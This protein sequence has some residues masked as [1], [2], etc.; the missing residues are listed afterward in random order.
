MDLK[1]VQDDREMY[2]PTVRRMHWS[3]SFFIVKKGA[4]SARR[5]SW[6][7]N[8]SRAPREQLRKVL[9]LIM[10]TPDLCFPSFNSLPPLEKTRSLGSSVAGMAR[11]S[12][13]SISM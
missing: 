10:S 12:S 13:A 2:R 7:P 4:S 6:F 3:D 11:Y 9:V 8:P 1:N 5:F